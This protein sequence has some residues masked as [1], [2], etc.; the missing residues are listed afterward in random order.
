[1]PIYLAGRPCI[2]PPLR[3]A[4]PRLALPGVLHGALLPH[5]PNRL[6][7]LRTCSADN[8]PGVVNPRQDDKDGDGLGDACDVKGGCSPCADAPLRGVG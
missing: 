7:P 4:A 1:M 3:V 6:P 8:C 2:P 5:A